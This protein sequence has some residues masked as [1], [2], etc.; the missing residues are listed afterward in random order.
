MA[1]SLPTRDIGAIDLPYL[2]GTQW[3]D[4][5]ELVPDLTWPLSVQMY[6]RMRRD[7]QLT[8]ILASATLPIRRANWVV[9]PAGCRDEVVQLVA[10]DMGL[11][12]LGIDPKPGPARRR[13]VIWEDHLR[14]ALLSLV[15]GHMPFERRYEI[16][17]QR[18]RLVNLG[19]RMP[20]T[21]GW[22]TLD[23]SGFV[24][25]I[26]QY[27]W[28]AQMP[29]PGARL[30]WY[31]HE[32]EGAAWTGTSA[33][34][35]AYAPWLLK[36]ELW[37]VHAT[38]IRR[39]GMGIPNV[40]APPGATPAQVQEASRLASAMRV[41]DQSGV[42]LP[43]GFKL[44]ITGMTGSV[45]D[46]LGYIRYFDQQMSTMALSGL[47]DLGSTP[48]GTRALGESFL[49]LFLTGLQAIADEIG[50]AATTGQPGMPG[51]VQD[52]VDVNWGEDEPIP[53][54]IATDVGERHELTAKAINELLQWGAITPDPQLEAHLRGEWKIPQRD[55]NAPPSGPFVQPAPTT[56]VQP[57]PSPPPAPAPAAGTSVPAPKAAR[58]GRTRRGRG[59][60]VR[61]AGDPAAGHRQLTTT[62]AASGVDPDGLHAEWAAALEAL[63]AAYAT[64]AA[65][66]RAALAA[67]ITAAVT[68]GTLADLGQLTVATGPAVQVLVDAMTAMAT[69][70]AARLIGEAASQGVTI[71]AADAAVDTDWLT[72][73]ATAIAQIMGNSTAAAAGRE[74][75]R[76]ATPDRTGEEVAQLVT[77]H[78]DGLTDAW[79]RLQLGGALTAAQNNG[80]YS[81]LLAGPDATYFA[82][83][84][85]D[86]FTCEPCIEIDGHEF[87]SVE[88]AGEAYATG[89]YT[90]C[91]GQLRCRGV[92]VAVWPQDG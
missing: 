15:F 23:K 53:K 68:A 54:I 49:D 85:L 78:L 33:L 5:H 73:T 10:D 20:W 28:G 6:A 4:V 43:P 72:A 30:V 47:L 87:E 16:R 62:E 21:I 13:G 19:E 48:N 12:I 1:P 2:V 25:S 45:P 67:Q 9:D 57:P 77:D 29:I 89:G 69:T 90:D 42:G 38:S 50:T 17:G 35:A 34:R 41:G 88:A 51:A 36:H 83:E 18:A 82:S 46:A 92:L 26:S 74:A 52:L 91:L 76:V 71:P 32:R 80:R 14:L 11:P 79:P 31:S 3:I 24:E 84:V 58:G 7:P 65:A 55:P 40:E 70:A 75:V 63:L 59:A 64:V 44:N 81:V 86:E 22:I 8:A 37:R 66:Q 56:L 61:A 39:F 27:T 60:G